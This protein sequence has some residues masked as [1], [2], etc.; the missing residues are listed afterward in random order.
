MHFEY[1][2]AIEGHDVALPP[3]L[4]WGVFHLRESL[5]PGVGAPLLALGLIGLAA[6]FVAP[7]ERLMPVAL[8]AAFAVLWYDIHEA[9]PLKPYPNFIR[10]MLPLVP[11]LAVLAASFVYEVLSRWDRRGVIA[12]LALVLA[13]LPALSASVRINA[14]DIDPRAIVPPIVAASGARVIVDR[15]GDYER[16]RRILGL[17]FRPTADMADI[18]VTANLA[19]D[20]ADN[21]LSPR[22]PDPQSMAGYY[23]GLF[24]RP[25]LEVSNGRPT[26]AYFNPV[27]RVVAMDGAVDRLNQIATEI[28]KAVPSLTVR[29]IEP[30]SSNTNR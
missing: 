24:S 16:A 19:Y 23:R 6:P 7:R 2:H 9:T 30:T 15:Y 21:Y 8:I 28:E 4:T 12:A 14:H 10:Y 3:Q 17:S 25:Y 5:W 11:L 29:L 26:L 27:L 1:R 22:D 13:A 18:V 20:R